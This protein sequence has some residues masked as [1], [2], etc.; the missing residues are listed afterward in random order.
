MRDDASL[1]TCRWCRQPVARVL[2][3]D[4]AFCSKRCRQTAFR[5]RLRSVVAPAPA[6]VRLRVAYAD[7]PYPGSAWRYRDQDSYGG[8]VDHGKLIA[9]LMDG[10]DGW[11]LSTSARALRHVLPLCPPEAKVCAWVKPHGSPQEPTGIYNRWEAVVVLPA[12][13]E[14]PGVRDWL[15]AHPARGGGT[16][17]GRKPIAFCAWLF[18]LLGMRA[19]DEFVD[20]FPGTGV[21]ARAWAELS[22]LEERQLTR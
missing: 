17:I 21:V 6:T 16:L 8:E 3:A 5:L 12:R 20:M 9:S 13:S 18:Q 14:R 7:P 11:A 1:R 15:Q 10:F 2:R 4:A 19:G 22:R